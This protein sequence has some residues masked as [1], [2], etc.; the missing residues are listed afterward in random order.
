MKERHGAMCLVGWAVYSKMWWGKVSLQRG[1]L[2]KDLDNEESVSSR[3][4]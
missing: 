1:Y 4:G 2:N 3:S